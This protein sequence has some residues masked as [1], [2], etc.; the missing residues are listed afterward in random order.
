MGKK[1]VF[2]LFLWISCLSSIEPELLSL[3]SRLFPQIFFFD[4][5]WAKKIVNGKVVFGIIYTQ[6]EA[7]ALSLSQLIRT[8]YPNGI[9]NIPLDVKV[10]NAKMMNEVLPTISTIILIDPMSSLLK[11]AVSY[12]KN[13][14]III[15]TALNHNL[16]Q[17][18]MVGIDIRQKV[19]PMINP[20]NIREGQIT[21]HQ[22]FINIAKGFE[23]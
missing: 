6:N 7:D 21:F 10:I 16:A 19:R 5:K 23:E 18:A 1:A 11:S 13:H 3:Q 2:I 22:G 9:K 17:G 12:A 20:G 14:Q 8:S 4:D 15:F